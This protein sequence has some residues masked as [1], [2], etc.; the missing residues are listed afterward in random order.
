MCEAGMR[1]N[2][3]CSETRAFAGV[4]RSYHNPKDADVAVEAVGMLVK[5]L[6]RCVSAAN[7][8]VST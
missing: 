8:S 6:M 3:S 4:G 2:S 1:Y 7:A 5:S